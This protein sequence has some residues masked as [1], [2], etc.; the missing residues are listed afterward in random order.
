MGVLI[1]AASQANKIMGSDSPGLLY[2][3]VAFDQS[4]DLSSLSSVLCGVG[5]IL[6]PATDVPGGKS[7]EGHRL[8]TH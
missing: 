2:S 3:W 8:G 6:A 4:R 7:A 1:V 5:M